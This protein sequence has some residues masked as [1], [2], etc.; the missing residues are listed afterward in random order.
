MCRPD[1]TGPRAERGWPAGR[2]AGSHAD[3]R[4][5]RRGLAQGQPGDRDRED[6]GAE[7]EDAG[8]EAPDE[9]DVGP[10]ELDEDAGP[11]GAPSE[12]DAGTPANAGDD[13]GQGGLEAR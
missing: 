7:G 9:A 2:L 10:A 4:S 1:H 6:E 11:G 13:A 8:P 12:A 5:V 3:P